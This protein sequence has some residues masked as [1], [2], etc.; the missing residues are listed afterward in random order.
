MRL[1]K[2]EKHPGKEGVNKKEKNDTLKVSHYT[3][4]YT[5]YKFSMISCSTHSSVYS[6][7]IKLLQINCIHAYACTT[8]SH[9]LKQKMFYKTVITP[10]FS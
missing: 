1:L 10:L 2:Q 8:V 7:Q 9:F 3:Y 6:V 5:I 4:L